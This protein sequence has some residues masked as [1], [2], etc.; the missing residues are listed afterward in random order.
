[1]H[2]PVVLRV[3]GA[4]NSATT[5]AAEVRIQRPHVPAESDGV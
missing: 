5:G 2:I 3:G 1:V 4:T